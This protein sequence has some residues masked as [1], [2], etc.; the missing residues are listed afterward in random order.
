MSEETMP[1]VVREA[2]EVGGRRVTLQKI[3]CSRCGERAALTPTNGFYSPD[4]MKKIFAARG[5]SVSKKTDHTC[6]DCI[7]KE[8]D[9]MKTEAP[10]EPKPS[11]NRR[12]FA[13]LMEVYDE[14]NSRYCDDWTDNAVAKELAVP[15]KWVEEIRAANFGPAGSNVEMERV[16][17]AIGLLS[18][19][20]KKAEDA[21]M[22]AA[23]KCEELQRECKALRERLHKIEIAVGP[24]AA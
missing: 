8:K 2:E 20:A 18:S 4:R 9:V 12:I 11:D 16:S 5:W 7:A 3:V 15:R 21:A 6:P 10:R 23:A 19:E 14:A 1:G 13:R 17:T 22:A 24:R